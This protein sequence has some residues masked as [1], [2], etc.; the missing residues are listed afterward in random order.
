[1]REMRLTFAIRSR[2]TGSS[3]DKFQ[4]VFTDDNSSKNVDNY[5][6]K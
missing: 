4:R 6:Q 1:M 5:Y 3:L 2:K